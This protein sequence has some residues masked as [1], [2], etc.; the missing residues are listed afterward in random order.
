MCKNP[1]MCGAQLPGVIFKDLYM[2]Q[3]EQVHIFL[4]YIFV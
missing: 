4:N 3:A 2:W 1:F